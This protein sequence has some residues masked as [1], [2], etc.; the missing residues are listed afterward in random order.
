MRDC[1]PTVTRA[2]QVSWT[3]RGAK[4]QIHHG[5]TAKI[6]NPN[7]EIRN[8]FEAR[9]W[10]CRFENHDGHEGFDEEMRMHSAKCRMN[11][12]SY[13]DHM[14]TTSDEAGQGDFVSHWKDFL[15]R[16]FGRY[17]AADHCRRPSRRWCPARPTRMFANDRS[18]KCGS[19]CLE[20]RAQ[21]AALQ[22]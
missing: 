4:G 20:Y 9:N 16:A 1:Y 6:R 17:L 7:T 14:Y 2:I 10:K 8:K 22:G 11:A 3:R 12:R 21:A 13:T 15:A 19:A 5:D 18:E